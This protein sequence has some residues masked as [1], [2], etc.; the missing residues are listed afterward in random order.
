MTEDTLAGGMREMHRVARK[1]VMSCEWFGATEGA[2]DGR[3]TLRNMAERWAGMGAE[4]MADALV[5]DAAAAAAEHGT[6]PPAETAET[7][8]TLV[9]VS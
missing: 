7:R 1:H 2:M 5:Y 4:V 9:R 6:D 3:R 8:M